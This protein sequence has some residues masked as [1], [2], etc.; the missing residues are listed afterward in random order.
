ME[1]LPEEEEQVIESPDPIDTSG[2]P[3][4]TNPSELGW[5][6][7][8][9]EDI[10]GYYKIP[11]SDTSIDSE[12]QYF[13]LPPESMVSPDYMEAYQ[14]AVAAA[15]AEKPTTN[16]GGAT[17]MAEYKHGAYGA[18]QAVGNRVAD[19]SQSAIVYIG[20]APVH[21]L[22]G[23]A[24]S[25]NVPI[26]VRN[27]AEA[28]K[29]FGYSDDWASYTLCE[30]MYVHLMQKGVGPLVLINVLDPTK[31]A[32]KKATATTASKTPVNGIITIAEAES[33]I[34]DSFTVAT[35]DSTPVTKV[36]G[37]DYTIAYNADKKTVVITSIGTGLGTSALTVTYNEIKP[38]GVAASDVIGTTDDLG[39]N[40]GLYAMRNVYQL[41]G[42]IPAFLAAPGFSSDPTVNAAMLAIARKINGHW[43]AYCF[44]DIPLADGATPL[45]LATVKTYKD[46]NGYNSPNET[47]YWPMVKGTD[48][49]KYHISVLAAGN[50]QELLI[51]QDGIPYKTAS[52]TDCPIIENLYEG[53]SVT[54]KVYDDSII[55]EKLN[56]NGIAS[57]AYVGGRWAIWGCHSA[58]YDQTNADKMN[59]SE[60]SRMMLYYIS[61]DFQHRRPVNVDKPM[62]AN[63]LASIVAEEQTRLDAL[64]RIGALTLGN[65]SLNAEYQDM[66][67][68]MNGDY[69][70]VF[71]VSTTPLAR[72]LTAI[73][74]WT[75]EGFI[76]YFE[77]IIG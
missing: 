38:D 20:T 28:R 34:L 69:S 10:A 74:N 30:A 22:E 77:N 36:K 49:K 29:Y 42:V 11:T 66:S 2:Y 27:I 37:E 32:H 24:K 12:K 15:T 64:L 72:S 44:A 65:V 73:V 51:D 13:E 76:T 41:T 53:E 6:E 55:N 60:T 9:P 35:Q 39:T 58:D 19:D 62:T 48:G 14:A 16:E 59:V 67:D 17:P 8:D 56:K 1:T 50:F 25:V 26:L 63:D 4:G 5:W 23:G 52:N 3:E 57:A 45:T 68:I 7:D 46:A 33:A 43:D 70:F 61:N 54:G 40:T 21:T 18:I 75:D 47:V 31:A 71:N